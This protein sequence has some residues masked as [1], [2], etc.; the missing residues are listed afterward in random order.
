MMVIVGYTVLILEMVSAIVI[1]GYCLLGVVQIG[2]FRNPVPVQYTVAKGALTGLTIKT[3]ATFLKFIQLMTWNQIFIFVAVFTL[4]TIL[5]KVFL[6]E[7]RIASK[8]LR[9]SA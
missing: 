7:Q 5:K 4:R 8:T 1:F 6:T 9:E 3:V 2:L